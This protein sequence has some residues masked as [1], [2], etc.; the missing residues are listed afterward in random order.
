MQFKKTFLKNIK[1]GD[2]FAFQEKGY[3]IYG[4]IINRTILGFFAVVF[5][6]KTMELD[7]EQNFDE[8]PFEFP[9]IVIDGMT[10]F[11]KNSDKD[12]GIIKSDPSYE[13]PQNIKSFNLVL[14]AHTKE[15]L[16]TCA[17]QVQTFNY[18]G[19]TELITGQEN[20]AKLENYS[21][22]CVIH[23]TFNIR[24]YASQLLGL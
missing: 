4:R 9:P 1:S 10:F 23:T 3:F 14:G 22:N 6:T 18:L 20:I 8:I 16:H 19:E 24:A 5:K 12:F 15:I 13:I 17:G 2:I 21:I 11:Q 7:V